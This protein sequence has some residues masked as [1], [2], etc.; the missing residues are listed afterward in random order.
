MTYLNYLCRSR[1]VAKLLGLFS[2]NPDAAFSSA[3]ITKSIREHPNS[4]RYQLRELVEI[5]FLTVDGGLYRMNPD[6]SVVDE[7]REL[8]TR[9]VG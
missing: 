8:A 5:S 3:D 4:L 7:I 2:T 6:C 1:I 9:E